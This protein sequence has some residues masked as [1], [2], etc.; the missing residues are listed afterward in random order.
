MQC[1]EICVANILMQSNYCM[2]IYIYIV[3]ACVMGD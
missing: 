1:F 2:C 3:N